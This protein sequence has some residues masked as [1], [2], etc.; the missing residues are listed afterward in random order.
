[1]C[2]ICVDIQK[3]KMTVDDGYRALAEMQEGMEPGHA[4]EVEDLLWQRSVQ[5]WYEVDSWEEFDSLEY[6]AQDWF[7]SD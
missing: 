4:E 7:G 5:E 6:L 1:M 2:L 3:D